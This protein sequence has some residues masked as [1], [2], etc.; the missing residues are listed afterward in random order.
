[1]FCKEVLNV[2]QIKAQ[3]QPT[4]FS[5]SETWKKAEI[6]SYPH[7]KYCK[8][9][10]AY[11][12]S[13][14]TY[15]KGIKFGRLKY[16]FNLGLMSKTFTVI[17]IMRGSTC[18]A[19]SLCSVYIWLPFSKKLGSI[20]FTKQKDIVMVCSFKLNR[21]PTWQTQTFIVLSPRGRAMLSDSFPWMPFICGEV[22]VAYTVCT[23]I[24]Q[25]GK[26]WFWETQPRSFSF[27]QKCF[28]CNPVF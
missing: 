13:S 17:F 22:S 21:R 27:S 12:L 18:V 11:K 23:K 2:T 28:F 6:Q 26:L 5:I 14:S 24:K 1:M 3:N 10:N 15:I 25:A 4:I 8:S 19:S 16:V 7:Q 9:C 20:A